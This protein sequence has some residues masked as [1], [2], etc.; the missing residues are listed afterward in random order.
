MKKIV[1]L[2]LFSFIVMSCEKEDK[3]PP[4]PAWLN[5]MISQLK[6]TP[7]PGISIYAYKWKEDYYYH[8]SNPL[9]SCKFCDVYDYSGG[10]L[11]WTDDEFAD[12]VKNGKMIK[13][14]WEK[15]F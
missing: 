9:S 15:G 4:N 10:K 6:N 8:V 11:S 7:L 1:F 3:L 14:V 13:A 5:T 2:F 12:F